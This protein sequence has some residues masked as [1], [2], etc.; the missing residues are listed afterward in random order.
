MH[1]NV[2]HLPIW[3]DLGATFLFALTGAIAATK[4]GYDIVGVFFLALSSGLGGALIRDSV[5][6][7]ASTP[8]PVLTD[9][10]YIAL[11]AIAAVL[12]ALFGRFIKPFHRVI[13]LID[14]VGLGAYAVFGV[15]KSLS[16]GL[17][18]PAALLVGVINAAG[19]GVLRDIITRE[20]PLAFKP[21][22]FYVL[23][24]LVGA[25]LFV[26]LT[27]QTHL[28]ATQAA[29]FAIGFT[30]IFR[31]LTIL[32]NWRTTPLAPQSDT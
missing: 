5:F 2:F 25:V 16:A 13:A 7:R 21:G 17:A 26:V 23:T 14:A 29:G 3:F 27:V 19:G 6:I 4:R 9:P 20:E 11:V 15:Q 1:D 24:A 8:T 31:S 12:G 32:F 22:Q 10:R 30:F 28:D 18:I